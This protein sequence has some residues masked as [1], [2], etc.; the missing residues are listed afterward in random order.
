MPKF[1]EKKLKEEYPDNPSAPDEAAKLF[2]EAV[3]RFRPRLDG[4]A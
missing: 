4:P 1:L 2:W 3:E